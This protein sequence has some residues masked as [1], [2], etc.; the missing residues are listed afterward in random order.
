MFGGLLPT[1]RQVETAWTLL[2]RPLLEIVFYLEL[3]SS[4]CSFV[5][6]SF[7]SG[8]AGVG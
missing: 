4:Q 7:V 8:V 1:S 3:I 2:A 5:V 6:D